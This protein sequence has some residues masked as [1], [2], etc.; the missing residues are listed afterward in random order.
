MTKGSQIC[1]AMC[2]MGNLTVRQGYDLHDNEDVTLEGQG[3]FMT[4]LVA[5]KSVQR[6]L[7]HPKE[8]PLFL[9]VAFQAPHGPIDKP[10]KKYMKK[11]NITKS[12]LNDPNRFGTI[13]VRLLSPAHPALTL[14]ALDAGVGAVVDALKTAGLYQNSVIVFSTG[15]LK[16]L[17]LDTHFAQITGDL[18]LS[19]TS[20]SGERK[21][22]CERRDNFDI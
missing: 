15:C 21:S 20:L 3:M 12:S 19:T 8:E 13:T 2:S 22:P 14:Q 1:G 9:F 18:Q 4:D 11:Y 6:I 10:P 7:A 5:R 16:L 17:P